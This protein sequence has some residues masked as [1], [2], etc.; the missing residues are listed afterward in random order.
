MAPVARIAL[1]AAWEDAS[2][3]VGV[4][5]PPMGSFIIPKT[6]FGLVLYLVAIL[7]QKSA[8]TELGNPSDVPMSCPLYLP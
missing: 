4:M 1:I 8:N 6:M 7:D 5:L 3:V 2:H